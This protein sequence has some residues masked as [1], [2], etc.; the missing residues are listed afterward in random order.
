MSWI[1][2]IIP[3]L[4]LK[5]KGFNLW[6]HYIVLTWRCS[7]PVHDIHGWQ[8]QEQLNE[9]VRVWNTHRIRHS[10]KQ[11][12]FSGRALL[13]Y[14][15]PTVY[16]C[17]DYS[18]QLEEAEVNTCIDSCFFREYPCYEDVFVIMLIFMAKL[19][20]DPVSWNIKQTINQST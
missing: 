6:K 18:M 14:T 15:M 10:R 8:W 19:S 12:V 11:N 20:S 16:G 1:N 4:T 7:Y 13:L 3:F 9:V 2:S 5:C 17:R